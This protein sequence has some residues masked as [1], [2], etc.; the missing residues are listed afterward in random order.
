MVGNNIILSIVIELKN[1][2]P[3]IYCSLRIYF[4]TSYLH[5]FPHPA[6][7]VLCGIQPVIV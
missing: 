6:D 3:F 1:L 2:L 4:R 5:W 7:N